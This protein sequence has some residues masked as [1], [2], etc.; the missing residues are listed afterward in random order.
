MSVHIKSS[1]L[2][3]VSVVYTNTSDLPPSQS[4]DRPGSQGFIWPAEEDEHESDD[5]DDFDD[6]YEHP[7]TKRLLQLGKLIIATRA[8]RSQSLTLTVCVF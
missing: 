7:E 6:P 3:D 5:E 1:S 2:T 8:A 4:L